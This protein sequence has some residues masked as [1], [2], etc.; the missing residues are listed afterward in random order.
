MCRAISACLQARYV[1]EKRPHPVFGRVVKIGMFAA[2]YYGV[3]V[4]YFLFKYPAWMYSYAVDPAHVPPAVAFVVFVPSMALTG[5]FG[6]MLAQAL[7]EARHT[8]TAVA[9]AAF[10]LA[11]N[12]IG[13]WAF[14]DPFNHVGTFAEFRAS[15][16]PAMTDEGAR[17]AAFRTEYVVA[18]ITQAIP[19]VLLL[20]WL[21]RE[22]LRLGRKAPPA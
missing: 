14:A 18:G 21:G 3:S 10:A 2:L 6:A 8:W 19:G 16:A 22:A 7:I 12:G 9:F 5:I 20:G 11:L 1:R 15:A 4:G 17:M 13:L